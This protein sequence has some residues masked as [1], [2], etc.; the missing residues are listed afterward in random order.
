MFIN[1]TKLIPQHPYLYFIIDIWIHKRGWHCKPNKGPI[2]FKFS[3]WSLEMAK[4]VCQDN[5]NCTAVNDYGCDNVTI[6]LCLEDSSLIK[7]SNRLPG[8][9]ID[10]LYEK[11]GNNILVFK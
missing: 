4:K 1:F 3:N 11:R 6:S 2:Q 9:K 10:C 5:E 8:D 7:D